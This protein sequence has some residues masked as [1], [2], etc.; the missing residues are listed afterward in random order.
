MRTAKIRSYVMT[1]PY[2]VFSIIQRQTIPEVLCKGKFNTR[3][4]IQ[5]SYEQE[6]TH[7][8]SYLIGLI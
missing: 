3:K 8:N 5:S 4:Q 7:D 2:G 1:K 6:F